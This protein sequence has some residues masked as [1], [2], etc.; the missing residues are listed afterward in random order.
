MKRLFNILIFIAIASF[1]AAQ[2]DEMRVIDSMQSVM[3]KQ[4]G[5][6]RV[7][8]M[9]ELARAMFNVSY[10]DCIAMGE[11]AIAGAEKLGDEDLLSWTHWKLGISFMDHYDFDL[12][13]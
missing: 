13:R 9:T 6:S 10:D 3:A 12:A 7:E 5:I 4:E 2:S 1:C 11:T 8:T